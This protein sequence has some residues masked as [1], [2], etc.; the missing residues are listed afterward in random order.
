MGGIAA[1]SLLVLS[2]GCGGGGGDGGSAERSI[3]VAAPAKTFEGGGYSFTYPGT[4]VKRADTKYDIRIVPADRGGSVSL[5][6][7]RDVLTTPVTPANI[8][9]AVRANRPAVDTYVEGADAVLD[10]G[11]TKL[12]YA[13]LPGLGFEA[14]LTVAGQ[15]THER[16]TWLFDGTTVYVFRCLFIPA[17]AEEVG[18]ACDL[19]LSSFQLSD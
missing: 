9:Q 16:G 12:T 3:D 15:P 19:V 17:Q 11:P 8:D 14:S 13:G 2:A 4:W 18:Q 6:V 1:L 10:S 7:H 5:I